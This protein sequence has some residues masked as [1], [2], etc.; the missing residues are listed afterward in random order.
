MSSTKVQSL[1]LAITLLV[2]GRALVAL[3]RYLLG[4]G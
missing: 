2:V 4:G 1:A 3:V